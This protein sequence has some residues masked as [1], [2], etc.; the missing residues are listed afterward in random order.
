MEQDSRSSNYEADYD[1][2]SETSGPSFITGNSPGEKS[3]TQSKALRPT[4]S[5]S[6]LRGPPDATVLPSIGESP[7]R[8]YMS[9]ST[10]KRKQIRN[11]ECRFCVQTITPSQ[12]ISHLKRH[13]NC[14]SM[15]LK[16][17]KVTDLELLTMK[18]FSC[19]VCFLSKRIDLAKHLKRDRNCL[20]GYQ[21]KYEL[22]DIES[23]VAKVKKLKRKT[24]SSRMNEVRKVRRKEM[25]NSKP[26]SQSL[27]EYRDDVALG[28]Y[29]TCVQC[30]SNFRVYGARVVDKNEEIFER[31]D[32]KSSEKKKLRRFRDFFI[33]NKCDTEP[34]E[35]EGQE[36]RMTTSPPVLVG[37][38]VGDYFLALPSE[39]ALNAENS[40]VTQDK[41]KVFFPTSMEAIEEG[42]NT[43][44]SKVNVHEVRKIY[45]TGPVKRSHLDYLYQ[46]EI[47]KY[48]NACEGAGIFSATLENFDTRQISSVEKITSTR[49]I[50]G[51]KEWC[52][53]VATNMDER[54]AQWGL[55]HIT[56]KLD[57]PR[58]R[59]DVVATCLLQEGIPVTI[60]K[61]GFDNGEYNTV[62]KVHLDHMSDV[63]CSDNCNERV[64]IEE[65]IVRQDFDI[66][67]NCHLGTYVNICHQK[68]VAFIRHIVKAPSSGLYSE[69]YHLALVFDNEGHASIVGS[70]WPE[71]LFSLNTE[72]SLNDGNLVGEEELILFVESNLASTAD[73]RLLRSSFGLSDDEAEVLADLVI[74]NQ[75]ND[76]GDQNN[77]NMCSPVFLPSLQTMIKQPCSKSNFEAS[78]SFLDIMRKRLNNLTLEEKKNIKTWNWLEN[79]WESLIGEI[80]DDFK[81]LS[82]QFE[83]EQVNIIFEMD[84][85]LTSFLRNF[86]NDPYTGAYHYALSCCGEARG[87]RIIHKRL[88]IIDCLFPPFNPLMIKAMS[89]KCVVNLVSSSELYQDY[90]LPDRKLEESE[91]RLKASILFS[92]RLLSMEEAVALSDPQIKKIQTSSKEVFV[93]TKEKRKCIVKKA[94]MGDEGTFSILGQS[95]Q[96]AMLQNVIS[97]HFSRNNLNDG[98]LLAETSIW[99]D[100][101]GAEDSKK[102]TQAYSTLEIP[103]SDEDSACSGGKLPEFILC[104]NGDVLK[105]RKR[106]KILVTPKSKNRR[107]EIFR[108]C[109]LFL[110]IESELDLRN[111]LLEEKYGQVNMN[112][113]ALDVEINEKKVFPMKIFKYSDVS[114]LDDLLVAL[115]HLSDNEAGE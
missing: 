24:F 63:D 93:N 104:R 37:T 88:W 5:D 76:C 39:E 28:N 14:Q 9:S 6:S 11:S 43:V 41:I 101:A 22:E 115:D 72:V 33:C 30:L 38:E 29:R 7:I 69:N 44:K 45:E 94:A 55:F 12:I 48:K 78:R 111:G 49:D 2:L 60:E 34:N 1:E 36:S 25:L 82:L 58:N 110:P 91:R 47:N 21:M 74:K 67:N 54:I 89:S 26:V 80:P 79:Q 46:L 114:Q 16:L 83:Q 64:T 57:L 65:Y 3:L 68:F 13:R 56:L 32:L 98:L 107:E 20:A 35:E 100:Y 10:A 108:K 95:E 53:T 75:L 42:M 50:T 77:N 97:R 8:R 105:K 71:A 112:E 66:K 70:I 59:D 27:N 15:Y 73:P 87:S 17:F 109:V 19:E 81:T 62:Y 23:I 99:Y 113:L 85:L 61:I 92:H 90:F 18:M 84:D 86:N 51:S 40:I 52:S 106:R 31:L 103:F 96:Y 4:L 102:L